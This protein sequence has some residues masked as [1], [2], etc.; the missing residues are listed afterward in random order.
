[1]RMVSFEVL[2]TSALRKPPS[3]NRAISPTNSPGLI[4]VDDIQTPRVNIALGGLD[5]TKRQVALGA[6]A[7]RVTWNYRVSFVSLWDLAW[8]NTHNFD[9]ILDNLRTPLQE[10]AHTSG[11]QRSL[12]ESMSSHRGEL[13]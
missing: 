6:C 11:L 8:G 3:W 2:I 5:M 13:I 9:A 7:K 1:M 4:S 10:H 12:T